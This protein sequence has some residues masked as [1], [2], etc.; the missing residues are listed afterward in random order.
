MKRICDVPGCGRIHQARGYCGTHYRRLRL[1]GSIALKTPLD[2]FMARVEKLE[3]GCWRWTG[4]TDRKGY[5]RHSG[6]QGAHRWLY[7]QMRGPIPD[8]KPLDHLCHTNDLSCPGGDDCP[9]RA[10]VNPDH[11]E[12]VTAV[13]N[14][15]RGRH[16]WMRAHREGTCVKGHPRTP[17]TTFA[18]AGIRMCL[19]CHPFTSDDPSH[20]DCKRCERARNSV[21]MAEE[22]PR[23]KT[24]CKQGHE[25]TPENTYIRPDNN[26]RQCRTC[27]R[28]KYRQEAS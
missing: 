17:E 26:T 15:E 10:C 27:S 19:V 7:E 16:P 14:T 5:G 4:K 13:E 25:Y 3:N 21:R 18:G 8:G 20:A 6:G 28:A 2:R 24:H 12:P 22:G 9:H 23:L 11:L 1:T